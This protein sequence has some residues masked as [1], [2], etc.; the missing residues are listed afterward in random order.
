MRGSPVG[1][2]SVSG[3]CVAIVQTPIS[4]RA[5]V[6]AGTRCRLSISRRYFT[7]VTLAVSSCP[8]SLSLYSRPGMQFLIRH[9]SDVRG[10]LLGELRFLG[11]RSTKG[12][13]RGR[14]QR[15]A[16]AASGRHTRLHC[17]L[18]RINVLS[19]YR[20]DR[21]D[22]RGGELEAASEFAKGC[23][24][25]LE[26]GAVPPGKVELVEGEHDVADTGRARARR[27]L[28]CLRGDAIT[29]VNEH[30]G[31]IGGFAT[32]GRELAGGHFCC[33]TP[34]SAAS[35]R[36]RSISADLPTPDA[37]LT[38]ILTTRNG[39]SLAG[40]PPCIRHSVS[41]WDNN[42]PAAGGH[43]AGRRGNT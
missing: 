41:G 15:D 21:N 32:V 26:R 14:A 2:S 39:P 17:A 20:R 34:K 40:G 18:Q 11:P 37:P 28:A 23:L 16:R 4:P 27:I 22:G 12:R 10:E 43:C 38:L 29:C 6:R 9:A 8:A 42:A 1:P 3:V 36:M 35:A 7:A 31:D 33:R 30:Y 25:R 19:R 13:R 5:S 24:D